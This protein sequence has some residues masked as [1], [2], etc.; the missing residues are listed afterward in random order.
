MRTNRIL[1]KGVASA[2]WVPIVA[3]RKCRPRVVQSPKSFKEKVYIMTL[4]VRLL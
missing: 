3:K 2:Q 1:S 4:F